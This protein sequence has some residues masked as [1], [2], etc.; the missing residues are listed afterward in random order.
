MQAHY[1]AHFERDMS[2]TESDWLQ[3][4]PA[5][6]GEVPWQRAGTQL[7]AEI[8]GG[9]LTLTWQCAPD[10]P[11]SSLVRMPRLWA[12]FDFVGV[13]D[14]SR[15]RFMKRFDLYMLRGGG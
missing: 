8:A 10:R 14:E 5:A 11:L 13:D 7:L 12:Q 15:H 9:R 3:R 2:C 6:L 1:P 4:L